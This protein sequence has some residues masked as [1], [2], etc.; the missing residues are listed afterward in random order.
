MLGTSPPIQRTQKGYK[1]QMGLRTVEGGRG[2]SD[3]QETN[4][5]TSREA[6]EGPVSGS[7]AAAAAVP[8]GRGR[9]Y[10]L[11]YTNKQPCRHPGNL[12]RCFLPTF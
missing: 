11:G 6:K 3:L 8:I 4:G 5:V 2:S 7:V 1:Q 12:P 9:Q 10:L